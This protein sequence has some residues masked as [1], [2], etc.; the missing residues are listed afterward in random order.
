[1]GLLAIGGVTMLVIMNMRTKPPSGT[2][3]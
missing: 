2:D 3:A 1:M